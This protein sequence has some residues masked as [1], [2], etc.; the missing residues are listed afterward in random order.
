[1]AGWVHYMASI[2]RNRVP[3]RP[4][5]HVTL[6]VLGMGMGTL[7]LVLG[8]SSEAGL[9]A[10]AVVFASLALMMGAAFLYILSQRKVPMGNI[11][12]KVGE[13][14]PTFTATTSEGVPFTSNA[15]HGRRV[16]LKFFRGSW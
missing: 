7:A 6:Q 11:R 15:L 10:L 9:G 16:L 12:L 3:V 2:P 5:A 1:M 14:L 8:V 4:V 13:K